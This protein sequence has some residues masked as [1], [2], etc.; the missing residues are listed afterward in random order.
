M[1]QIALER[2]AALGGEGVI[3]SGLAPGEG[4]PAF[5]VAAILDD[6]SCG[7]LYESTISAVEVKRIVL[8]VA[9]GAAVAS[10]NRAQARS[11]TEG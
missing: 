3:R 4:F 8:I 7:N 5:D 10:K 1:L 2:L 11:H 6:I 9:V